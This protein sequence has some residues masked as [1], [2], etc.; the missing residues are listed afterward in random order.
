MHIR[1]INLFAKSRMS[2]TNLQGPRNSG[3][4]GAKVCCFVFSVFVYFLPLFLIPCPPVLRGP[5]PP[6]L[7]ASSLRA[8]SSIDETMVS[9]L[10][11]KLVLFVQGGIYRLSSSR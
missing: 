1:Q 10:F 11:G 4:G 9:R 6:A 3:W 8:F 7:A 5:F 2:G